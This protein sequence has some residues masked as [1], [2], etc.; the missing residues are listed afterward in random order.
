MAWF[1]GNE[2]E[3]LAALASGQAVETG[4]QAGNVQGISV[5]PPSAKVSE[6]AFQAQVIE[7]AKGRGWQVYHPYDSRKSQAGYPDLTLWRERL[8][9]AE[10]KAETGETTA[11]QEKCIEELRAAGQEVYLWRPSD[12]AAIVEVLR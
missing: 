5:P 7:Y 6:A 9:F 3:I 12:M 11:A 8:V 10:L 1:K 4:R 2:P